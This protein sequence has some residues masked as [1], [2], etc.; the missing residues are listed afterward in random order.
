[1]TRVQTQATREE[2]L[3]AF[4]IE[5]DAGSDTLARY[6]RDYPQFARELVDLGRELG[7]DV[8]EDEAPLS[9]REHAMID[10]AWRRH[11]EAAPKVADDPFTTLST[12]DLREAAKRLDVPRQV[13]TAFRERRVL[14]SSV[15]KRFLARL[16]EAVNS[17]VDRLVAALSMPAPA[18]ARSYKADGKPAAA[19]PVNFEQVL[20]DAG[21]PEERRATL[22]ADAD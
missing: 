18:L 13:V 22:L 19:A 3:D 10:A 12:A 8:C 17:T 16:A 9:E 7:R 2:V 14:L 1:M 11:V 6:L 15:P 21:V 5:H 4:A 20:I